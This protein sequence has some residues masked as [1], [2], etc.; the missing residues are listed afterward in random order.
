MR[1]D[2]EL[3]KQTANASS[4][5]NTC[6]TTMDSVT[7]KLR[8][9]STSCCRA[10]QGAAFATEDAAE[11]NALSPTVAGATMNGGASGLGGGH[12]M[13]RYAAIA[14]D[15]IKATCCSNQAGVNSSSSGKVG[16]L[17]TAAAESPG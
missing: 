11:A 6:P 13:A 3:F 12:S 4:E 7:L 14:V 5:I 10:I 17:D 8:P 16:S 15:G 1:P 2:N 9:I